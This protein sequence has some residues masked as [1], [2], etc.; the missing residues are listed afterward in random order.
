MYVSILF[1]TLLLIVIFYGFL[2]LSYHK[3]KKKLENINNI[4]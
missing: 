2:F 1:I 4:V 3:N